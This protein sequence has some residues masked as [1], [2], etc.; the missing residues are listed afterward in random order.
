MPGAMSVLHQTLLP[1][2]VLSVIS[3]TSF[4]VVVPLFASIGRIR[5]TLANV[6][7]Y[8]G[9][10]KH[11]LAF[12]K[13]S[14]GF[15]PVNDR[16]RWISIKVL[17]EERMPDIIGSIVTID[18]NDLGRSMVEGGLMERYNPARAMQPIPKIPLVQG[19]YAHERDDVMPAAPVTEEH[20]DG[21]H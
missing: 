13:R 5:V 18:G 9:Q 2:F 4:D 10:F 1:G 11:A 12:A 20:D 19:V 15:E 21:A 14:L 17:A 7:R 8:K 6:D 16:L 3:P